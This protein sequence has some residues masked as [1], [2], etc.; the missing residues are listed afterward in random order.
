MRNCRAR[1]P[2]RA[3][4]S[5]TWRS[6]PTTA[7][8]SWPTPVPV[9]ACR[10]PRCSA[11]PC[12]TFPRAR[13]GSRRWSARPPPSSWPG[14]PPPR[15]TACSPNTPCTWPSPRTKTGRSCRLGRWA[16]GRRPTWRRA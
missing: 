11:G 15:S 4:T 7:S 16:R 2:P 9:M 8:A 14:S 6:T 12:R 1:Q 10:R 3:P 13:R 5:S